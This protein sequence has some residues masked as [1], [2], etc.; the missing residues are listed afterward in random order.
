QDQSFRN[1]I[2]RVHIDEAYNIY[3]AGLPHHGEAA[4]HPA[5]SKLG[6]FRVLLS[7]K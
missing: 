1:K 5:Y 6:E 4:F 7:T 3:T 2:H